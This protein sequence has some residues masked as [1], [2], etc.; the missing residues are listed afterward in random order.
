MQCI[1]YGS[2][3]T[4]SMNYVHASLSKLQSMARVRPMTKGL[5]KAMTKAFYGQGPPIYAKHVFQSLIFAISTV[6]TLGYWGPQ[7]HRGGPFYCF[8]GGPR[9]L[10]PGKTVSFVHCFVGQLLNVFSQVYL[11]VIE[12]HRIRRYMRK[13]NQTGHN[14]MSYTL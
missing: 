12:A 14:M 6:H 5:N 7:Y 13:I 8:D 11:V 9:I 1:I 3:C 10:T 4:S 2:L